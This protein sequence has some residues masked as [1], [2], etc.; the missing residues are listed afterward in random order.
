VKYTKQEKNTK[1]DVK[2][3][4][5]GKRI[6]VITRLLCNTETQK[7]TNTGM[8]E[9]D[10]LSATIVVLY[11]QNA[12]KSLAAG[13]AHDTPPEPYSAGEGASLSCTNSIL[14]DWQ[15]CMHSFK[16]HTSLSVWFTV[17]RLGRLSWHL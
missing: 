7:L 13:G 12:Q 14:P 2:R 10:I 17:R 1:Q 3:M 5:W 15:I 6:L 4:G 16:W 11:A 8:P 9:C